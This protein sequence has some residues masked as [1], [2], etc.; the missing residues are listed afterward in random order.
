[1][2]TI[3]SKLQN[4]FQANKKYFRADVLAGVTVALALIP[5][6]IAFAFVA[7]VTP[8][9]SLQTAAMIAIIAAIFSGR[10]GMISSSTAAIAVVLAPLIALHGL[11][12]LS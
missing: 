7:G 3:L 1:M 11:E 12:Y 8:L 2:T 6:A 5:E 9:L 4:S 10:P